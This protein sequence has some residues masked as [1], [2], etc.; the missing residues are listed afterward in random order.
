[1]GMVD[2]SCRARVPEEGQSVSSLVKLAVPTI[3][4]RVS[5]RCDSVVI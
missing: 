4:W 1:M 3:V 5:Q 2:Q